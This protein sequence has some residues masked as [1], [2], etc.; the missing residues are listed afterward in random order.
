MAKSKTTEPF[1]DEILDIVHK[2][3]QTLTDARERLVESLR[4][5]VPGDGVRARKAIDEAFDYTEKLL[6]NQ[7]EFAHSVLDAVLGDEPKKRTTTKRTAKRAT[8]KRATAKRTAA[9]RAT[10]KRP[11]KSRAA[12]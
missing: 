12:A 3:E 10:K 2:S 5:L 1:S 4:D 11:A 9:K 8:A 6:E 7:R